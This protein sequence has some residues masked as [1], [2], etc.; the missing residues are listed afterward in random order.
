MTPRAS[1][2]SSR[3]RMRSRVR[4]FGVAASAALACAAA[5]PVLAQAPC[6]RV[7]EASG[8]AWEAPLDR[9]VS[10]RATELT[11][12]DALDRISAAARV[13]LSYSSDLIPLD[14]RVC[15]NINRKPLGDVLAALVASSGARPVAIGGQVVLSP[16]PPSSPVLAGGVTE[17]ESVLERIVATGSPAGVARRPLTV[18]LGIVEGRDLANRSVVSMAEVMNGTVPGVW[19][20]QRSPSSLTSQYGSVRGA[21][22][23][24]A[25]YPKVYIDGVE[26]ANPLVLSQIDPD[27]VERVEVIRG[28]QGA[29][30]YGSDAI[31][32]VVNI[33]T[34]H[35]GSGRA[36]PTLELRSEGG[37]TASDYSA[38]AVP[39]H[40]QHLLL[41]AGDNLRSLGVAIGVGGTGAVY[42]G[43]GTREI[44]ALAA[45]RLVGATSILTTTLRFYDQRAGAGSNPLFSGIA[46]PR[47]AQADTGRDGRGGVVGGPGA[48]PPV[49]RADSSSQWVR[50][51]TGGATLR[52]APGGRWSYTLLAG[53]D[54]YRLNHLADSTEPFPS[55]IADPLQQTRGGADR[56]TLR[57]SAATRLG[58]EGPVVTDVTFALEHAV[59]R[60]LYADRTMR[61]PESGQGYAREEWD[62]RQLW[63]HDTGVLGQASLSW[64]NTG[65]LNGGV[66]VERNDAF[67]SGDL[68]SVLPMLGGAWVQSVGAADVKVRAAYGRGIRPARTPAR[69]HGYTGGRDGQS[70]TALEPESQA[71]TEL[72]VEVY[73]RR[74]FSLQVTRFDQRATGLIQNVL[75][76]EDTLERDGVAYRRVHYQLQ[77]VGEI[78]NRGWEM[79]SSLRQGP[80]SATAALSLVDSRVRRVAG[81]YAGDLAVG[82]R[83]LGVPR[84][85][86]GL[87]ARWENGGWYTA[88]TASRAWSWVGYDRLA[89]ARAYAADTLPR[90]LDGATL[91][92]FWRTYHGSTDLR[93]TLSRQV[94]GDIRV[95]LTG[96]NLLG[97]QLGEPDNA[98]IRAGRT[99]TLA[100][101]T[102]F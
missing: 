29:A 62:T 85:T 45:G 15:V 8:R 11:L 3:A 98:T 63:R 14:R 88:L 75:T 37:V 65:F 64:R 53:M 74:A 71:G 12:R 40:R 76:G 73:L 55:A 23:F 33:V 92:D 78:T 79:E 20:W 47:V 67:A 10:L 84:G 82:D 32:G 60:E 89:L 70:P 2:D 19:V 44:D 13:R 30:L 27:F 31:S 36:L 52:L 72:G 77:N 101:R 59:L 17:R 6:T 50:E 35:E 48:Y 83:V 91:R 93:A 24:G 86:T 61:R 1:G 51:Y 4:A 9:A 87:T 68:V 57:A 38:T 58:G 100:L 102:A 99:F 21:S 54:G 5:R 43:A 46:P 81:G 22:S 26:T 7:A 95:T 66:R 97:T 96:A 94:S 56:G 28:P 25:T 41:R 39:T 69:D 42:R 90:P 16:A 34:R 18:G 80:F 49:T